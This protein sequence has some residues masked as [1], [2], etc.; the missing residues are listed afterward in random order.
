MFGWREVLYMYNVC[1]LS[2][3]EK[4]YEIVFVSRQ[5]LN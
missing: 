1:T 4:K 5:K 2:N 3:L